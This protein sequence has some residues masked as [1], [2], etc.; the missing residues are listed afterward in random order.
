[1]SPEKLAANQANAQLSTGP[2]TPE[3]KARASQNALKHGLS[4]RELVIPAEDKSAFE[5]LHADYLAE[6]KPRGVLETEFF[7]AIVHAA[8]NLRRVRALEAELFDGSVDPLLD[9]QIEAK[10]DRL[11]RYHRRFES[12]LHRSVR[13]LRKLQTERATRE[14][15]LATIERAKRTQAPDPPEAAMPSPRQNEP[16]RKAA[17]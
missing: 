8:W 6:L 17:A 14:V 16:I 5:E 3:G 15:V 7:N 4:A 13:E 10:L 1:M 9:E 11:S 2:R 12:T